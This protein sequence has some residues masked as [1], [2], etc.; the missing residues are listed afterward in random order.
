MLTMKHKRID[1]LEMRDSC[2]KSKP[3]CSYANQMHLGNVCIQHIGM[4]HDK[5]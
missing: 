1:K 2:G 4:D 5:R 3:Y